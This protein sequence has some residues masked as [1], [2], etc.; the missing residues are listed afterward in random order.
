MI[1]NLICGIDP[2]LDGALALVDLHTGDLVN[3]YDTP[4]LTL[5]NGREIDGYKLAAQVDQWSPNL[6]EVWIERVSAR[7]GEGVSSSFTF[8][9]GYGE[10]CG[11]V[12]ANF[13]PLRSVGAA[14]WK[15]GMG[16]TGDKDESR[17]A[18]SAIWPTQEWRWPLKKHHGRAEAALIAVYGR[19]KFLADHGTTEAAHA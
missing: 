10:L 2:G 6:T 9:R 18:A 16:V 1:R 11:I 3:V 13:I 4:T 19:R 14:M 12:Y 8:G 15:R 7:P 17:K 5:K